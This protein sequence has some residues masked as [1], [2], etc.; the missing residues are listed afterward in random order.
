MDRNL[1]PG[2]VVA[3]M[4]FIVLVICTIFS[5]PEVFLALPA[6]VQLS[7]A[8]IVWAIATIEFLAILA[9]ESDGRRR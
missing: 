7:I 1:T 3:H 9:D 2:R 4:A 8:V 5:I 6:A